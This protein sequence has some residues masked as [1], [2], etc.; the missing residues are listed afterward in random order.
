[1]NLYFLVEGTTEGK[2]YPRWMDYF[3]P[4]LSKVQMADKAT[5]NNYFLISGRG[6]PNIL[7][8]LEN[9]IADINEHG[10]YDILIVCLDADLRSIKETKAEVNN[11]LIKKDIKLQNCA[12]EIIVQNKCFETWF[13]GNKKLYS[14]KAIFHSYANF[15]NVSENDPELMKKPLDFTASISQ[16]HAKYLTEMLRA[17]NIRYSKTKPNDVIKASYI[18]AL[19]QR[20]QENPTHLS[21]L[22]NFFLFF[23]SIKNK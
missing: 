23:E 13:L 3:F 10:H 14:K 7:K 8:M 5:E 15:Y 6:F 18:E 9:S 1:M 22:K 21:S 20:I 19:K 12:L 17:N 4:H 2:V 16:Y 11:F